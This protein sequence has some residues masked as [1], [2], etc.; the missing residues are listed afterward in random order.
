MPERDD[1]RDAV[2]AKAV[3]LAQELGEEFGAV[4]LTHYQDADTL[5]TIRG[6]EADLA[7]VAA[8]NK[9]VAEVFTAHGVQVL[10]QRADK[11]AFRRWM[12][13]RAETE[14]NRLAWIDR[15][16]LIGGA[17]GLKVVGAAFVES[18]GSPEVGK[19]P[20]PV[21][22]RVLAAYAKED[23]SDYRRI[24]EV[25]IATGRDDVIDLALR[26]ARDQLEEGAADVLAL[27][28]L[29]VA[30]GVEA[31]PSGWAE[32]VAVPMALIPG[33][34]PDAAELGDGL[35][36]SGA[37]PETVEV[38]FL[39]GWRSPDALAELRPTA[40]RRVLRDLLAGKEPGDLPPGDTDDLAKS[41]FGVLLGVLVDWDIPVWESILQN[42]LP[43]DD[44]ELSGEDD[45]NAVA[46]DRWRMTTA[47]S[48]SGCVALALVRPTRVA[49]EIVVFMEEAGDHT[50]GIEEI[51]DFIAIGQGEA[52]GE[53][54]VCCPKIFGDGLEISLYTK[55]G[56][57][58]DRLTMTADQLPAQ[59]SE[60]LD[61]LETLV[62]VVREPP[63]V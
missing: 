24:V 8:V 32:L 62:P 31:G 54:V 11:G 33:A 23:D 37:F 21:A 46:F 18:P 25:L 55:S 52:N 42:G 15:T 56:R 12:T 49:E 28:F 9:A 36:A 17:A 59:A 60:M 43:E 4:V 48:S 58:L 40:V 29:E 14:A 3:A 57:Y 2:V 53:E 41:G 10:V 26:K 47:D 39:P 34:V 5:D 63:G 16:R 51:V 22:D 19:I 50:Q 20:G 6:G 35:S 27:E 1:D 13:D 30:E 44:D 38:R 7:T 45:A 61:L